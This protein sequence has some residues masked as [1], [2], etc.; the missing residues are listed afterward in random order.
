MEISLKTGEVWPSCDCVVGV[1]FS[2]CSATNVR[3][4]F[5]TKAARLHNLHRSVQLFCDACSSR[6]N[7]EV[8][9]S[10]AAAAAAAAESFWTDWRCYFPEQSDDAGSH[11]S[12]ADWSVYTRHILKYFTLLQIWD[13]CTFWVF[14]FHASLHLRGKYCAFCYLSDCFTH[15]LLYKLSFLH[16]QHTQTL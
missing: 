9:Y 4:S 6:T 11:C 5:R 15:W 1:I 16:T 8:V 2:I 10:S 3:V 7:P 14:C 13:T 12:A